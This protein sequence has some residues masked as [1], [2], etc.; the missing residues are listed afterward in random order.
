MP[1]L[2]KDCAMT[3]LDALLPADSAL[4][5][6]LRPAPPPVAMERARGHARLAFGA[7][8]GTTRLLELF[9]SG[10]AK[11]RLPRVDPGAPKEAILINTAGGVTGGDHLTYEIAAG[12]GSHAVVSTQ[13]AERIYKRSAGTG[14]IETA[15]NVEAGARLDWL[16]QETILFDRSSLSRRLSID[17]AA[18]ATLLAAEAIILGRT[19]MGETIH[20]VTLADSWRVRRGGRLIFADGLRL[21]GDAT[22]IMR[23]GT[24]GSGA[25]ALATVLLV[26]P[27]AEQHL[28]AARAALETSLGEAGV[29]AWNGMLVARLAASAGHLLRADLI[30]LLSSLRTAPLPRVWSL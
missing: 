25:I 29:S 26:A 30:K 24:T 5:R 22:A 11:I 7:A 21:D 8:G 12:A 3:G 13:A 15:I 2:E 20:E 1:H 17:V 18:G 23:N 10:S 19:A 27:D 16:P 28:E 14:R 9:Q 6:R 4:P